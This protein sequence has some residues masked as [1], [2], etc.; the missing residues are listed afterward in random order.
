MLNMSFV[1]S[2]AHMWEIHPIKSSATIVYETPSHDIQPPFSED[3]GRSVM[4][5]QIYI[6]SVYRQTSA[7]QTDYVVD[8]AVVALS[9][10][11]HLDWAE[12]M[13]PL[14]K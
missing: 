13:L 9:S 12:S 5:M 4:Q 1:Y 14:R 6:Q 11:D 7:S 2:S 3:S 8:Q 10:A